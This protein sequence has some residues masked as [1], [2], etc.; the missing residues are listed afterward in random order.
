VWP[1]LRILAALWLLK[2]AFRLLRALAIAAIL[3]ALWPVTVTAAVA[4]S[5]AWLRGWPPA[6]LYRAA[7]WSTVAA[8]VYLVAA[9]MRDRSARRKRSEAGG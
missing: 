8:A 4:G 3:A 6:R 7:A 9:A 2:Q 5:A 1:L